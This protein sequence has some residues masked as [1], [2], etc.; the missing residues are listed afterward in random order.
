MEF[1]LYIS[2]AFPKQLLQMN[3]ETLDYFRESMSRCGYNSRLNYLSLRQDA[4]N[5]LFEPFEQSEEVEWLLGMKRQGFRFGMVVSELYINNEIP[6][7]ESGLA[8]MSVNDKTLHDRFRKRR[9]LL[10]TLIREA[11]F[12]WSLLE[13]S[14]ENFKSLNP[15]S[16]FY[17]FGHT[18]TV[19]ADLRRSVKDI[20]I[21]FIGKAT[22]YRLKIIEGLANAGL[23]VFAYGGDFPSGHLP[24]LLLNSVYDRAK[25]GLNL[26]LNGAIPTADGRDQRFASCT[27]IQQMLARE[28][29]VVCEEIPWDNPYRPYMVNSSVENLVETFR[30]LLSGDAWHSMGIKNSTLFRAEMDAAII[31][32]PVIDKSVEVFRKNA[33]I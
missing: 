27:R 25:I 31:C 13:R 14:G 5:I 22:P 9:G 8:L 24:N 21:L 1:N 16:F 23:S 33:G 28:I 18:R 19:P 29:C 3:D 4:I 15:N 26:T 17:P 10:E 30:N 32:K 11:E 6:Y 20:D 7:L 12:S 2:G